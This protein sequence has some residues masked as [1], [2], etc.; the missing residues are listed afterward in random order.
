MVQ[1]QDR[2]LLIDGQPRLIFSG[3]IHYWRLLRKEW[4]DRIVKAKELGCNAIAAYIPWIV[5][6]TREGDFDL[7]GIQKPENDL[8]A[9]IDL[10]HKHGLYFIGRPGPFIM[11]E[12]KNEG[13]PHWVAKTYPEVVPQTWNGE[14]VHT[15]NLQYLSPQFLKLAERWYA[16]VM[17]VLAQ[18]L[19]PKGGPVIGVQLDNEMG[20]LSWVSNEPDLGEDALCEFAAWLT[21]QYPREELSK[22]YPF[23]LTDPWAR[24]EGAQKPKP[25]YAAAFLR[26]YGDF[27]RAYI[28]KYVAHLRKYAETAG[29]LDVPF[30][31]NVHGSGGGRALAFPIGIHQLFKAYTQDNGYLA[32]SDHYLG[33][34]TRQNAS[35]LYVLNAFMAAVS[36]PE[37]PL[38]SM[39]FEVGTGDYGEN[40]Q[41]RYGPAAADFKVRLS[42]AQGN[43]LINYYML[44]GGHNPFLRDRLNDG[45]GRVANTGGRH[46]FAAPISPEGELDPTYFALQ[47]TTQAMLEFET[48]LAEA[49]EEYDP[50]ALAFVPD[51]YK[52]DLKQGPIMEEIV[53]GLEATREVLDNFARMMLMRGLRY[54]AVDIQRRALDPAKALVFAAGRY[55]DAQ[56][57]QKIVDYIQAG[58]RLLIGSEVPHLD[59]EGKEC[60]ILADALGVNLGPMLQS[61]SA[62]NLA[63]QGVGWA[64]F[65]PELAQW[66][67]HTFQLK[68]RGEVFLHIAN[69]PDACGIEVKLGSGKAVIMGTPYAAHMRFWKALFSRLDA[70]PAIQHNDATAGLVVTSVRTPKGE[71]FLTVLNLDLDAK[72]VKFWEQGK[73]LFLGE[74]VDLT[75]RGSK[76]IPIV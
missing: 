5:H 4:E 6:E 27:R 7:T 20:M 45:N 18:R 16:Q 70:E 23:K 76:L 10:A 34:L 44:A 61:S 30:I 69:K 72:S 55:L 40:G 12:T 11:A 50:V 52:T 57:Q 19:Q 17:P 31:V 53:S 74:A 26:D 37:Q 1:L 75:P 54:T 39:E 68:G 66:Q 42:V 38:A 65:E 41:L 51:Y 48:Q 2:M 73:P 36:R 14:K 56:D 25:E 49:E 47:K 8:G 71:R 3:E 28:A 64:A 22:R 67:T 43:R 29:I 59:M 46:G 63:V 35:D 24:R 13:I 15:S 33:D 62:W 9:F 21:E 60:T 58:G 32:G